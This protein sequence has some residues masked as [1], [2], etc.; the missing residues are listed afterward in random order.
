[1]AAPNKFGRDDQDGSE[2]TMRSRDTAGERASDL[3]DADGYEGSHEAKSEKLVRAE[4]LVDKLPVVTF[5]RT[6]PTPEEEFQ[7][8][9]RQRLAD[10]Q[11]ADAAQAEQEADEIAAM[12]EETRIREVRAAVWTQHGVEGARAF[13]IKKYEAAKAIQREEVAERKRQS[14]AA[15]RAKARL[16]EIARL[17]GAQP[18]P[19]VDERTQPGEWNF[20]K[21]W[22]KQ[23]LMGANASGPVGR[24]PG[25]AA[26]QAVRDE[27]IKRRD[28]WK[29][30]P[31]LK[32]HLTKRQAEAWE[33]H[34]LIG[35]PQPAVA[36]MM[37]LKNQQQV[38]QMIQAV[39]AKRA[40]L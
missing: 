36:A 22:G 21:S 31:Y 2:G 20:A 19:L 28:L 34:I 6:G 38:S 26:L 10:R 15:A 1:M 9:E 4:D 39:K 25:Q 30:W 8:A 27:E 40:Q 3:A 12:D 37:G 5:G 16:A 18:D 35:H 23:V 29:E 14:R 24:P 13:W 17:M 7:A 32:P 33:L 11:A